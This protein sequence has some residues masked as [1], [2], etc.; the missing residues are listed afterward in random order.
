MNVFGEYNIKIN[1]PKSTD[2]KFNSPFELFKNLYSNY[3]STFLLESMESDSGLARFSVLG[4]KPSAIL[5]AKDNILEIETDGQKQEIEVKNP[6]DEN[7][8][9]NLP[10]KW[11]KRI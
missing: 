5:R 9:T 10:I 4:F 6:F 7:Q 1:E 3:T 2:L 11:K 8:K